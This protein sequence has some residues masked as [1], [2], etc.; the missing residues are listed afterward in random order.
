MA[1]ITIPP[2]FLRE[3]M[4]VEDILN[5]EAF[6]HYTYEP[7]LAAGPGEDAKTVQVAV[8]IFTPGGERI[9]VTANLA[10]ALES[11]PE[12]DFAHSSI[13]SSAHFKFTAVGRALSR[14]FA[15]ALINLKPF[16]ALTPAEAFPPAF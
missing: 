5:A 6:S 10:D 7:I 2:R 9:K 3:Y 13:R 15:L 1:Q 4:V 8:K 11:L 12:N 16:R 14:Y